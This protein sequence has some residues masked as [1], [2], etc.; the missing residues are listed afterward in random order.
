MGFFDFLTGGK[1]DKSTGE[2]Q[3]S[4]SNLIWPQVVQ[5]PQYE[6]TEPRLRLTSD[7]LSEGIN[8]LREGRYPEYYENAL[9]TLRESMRR[10]L[11]ETY[12]GRAGEPGLLRGAYETG[13][14]TGVG[15]RATASLAQRTLR[16]YADKER[17]IDEQLVKLGVDIMSKESY[18]YPML[19]SQMPRGPE[20]TVLNPMVLGGQSS[21]GDIFKTLAQ[22]A[23]P[24]SSLAGADYGQMADLFKVFNQVNQSRQTPSYYPRPVVTIDK[25]TGRQVFNPAT[26]SSDYFDKRDRNVISVSGLF[27]Q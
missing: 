15:P 17:Q 5:V 3:G 16:D 21:T 25:D 24:M 20:Y 8:R 4:Q 12:Y 19:A 26:G 22:L 10:P 2:S 14:I 1:R 23:G 6:F 11:Y 18:N 7:F 9:P 13:S 27:N